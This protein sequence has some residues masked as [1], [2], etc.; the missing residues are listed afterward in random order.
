MNQN[1]WIKEK[2]TLQFVCQFSY[3]LCYLATY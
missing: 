2:Q 1:N 3:S